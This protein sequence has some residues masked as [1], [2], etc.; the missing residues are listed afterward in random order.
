MKVAA[1]IPG[2]VNA[3]TVVFLAGIVSIAAPVG[4]RH[5]P[6][7]TGQ[8]TTGVSAVKAGR[9]SLYA[10]VGSELTRYDADVDELTLVKRETVRL[11]ANVQ[12]AWPHPS[13]RYLYVGWSNQTSDL[14]PVND[15]H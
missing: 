4:D 10:S 11:P 12:E 1:A 6:S 8:T 2:L 9:V 15:V 14:D 3:S 7:K 5:S 13:R